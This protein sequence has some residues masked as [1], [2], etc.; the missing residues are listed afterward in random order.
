MSIAISPDTSSPARITATGAIDAIRAFDIVDLLDLTAP[1]PVD[2]DVA[3]VPNISAAALKV[4]GT[5]I[6]RDRQDGRSI[7]FVR[8]QPLV[9]LLLTIVG[10]VALDERD[11]R[12]AA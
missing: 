6:R 7:T 5:V 10:L 9:D 11:G 12:L 3:D 1:E 4:L 8:P 2:I